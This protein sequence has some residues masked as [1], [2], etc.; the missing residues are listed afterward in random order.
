M[1]V[2]DSMFVTFYQN[3]HCASRLNNLLLWFPQEN[4]DFE[5]WEDENT[6]QRLPNVKKAIGQVISQKRIS[7]YI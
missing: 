4:L 2:E 5:L 6:I 7:E 1:E 3:K